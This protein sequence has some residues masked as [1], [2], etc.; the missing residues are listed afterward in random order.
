[1]RVLESTTKA[2]TLIFSCLS[3]SLRRRISTSTLVSGVINT[4]IARE[5][6]RKAQDDT[7]KVSRSVMP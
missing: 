5:I 4:R 1:V 3:E 6:L 7:K 2:R